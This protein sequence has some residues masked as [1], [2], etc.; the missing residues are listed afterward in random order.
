MR[1]FETDPDSGAFRTLLTG[2]F[3]DCGG[4]GG[5]ISP[6][7]NRILIYSRE[8]LSVLDLDTAAVEAL[9]GIAGC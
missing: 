3:P 9:K 5:A 8:E 4:G 7:G 2:A 6:D 1:S